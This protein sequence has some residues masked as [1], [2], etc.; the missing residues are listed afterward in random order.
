M[1]VIVLGAGQEVGRSSI[2]IKIGN[3]TI[4]LDCGIHISYTDDRRYPLFKDYMEDMK[5]IDMVFITHFHLDHCGAIPYLVNELKYDGP[6][7]MTKPTKEIIPIL[8]EDYEKIINFFSEKKVDLKE[9]KNEIIASLKN[10]KIINF[11]EKVFIEGVEITTYKAGHVLGAAMFHISYDNQ[12]ILYTG[13]FNTTP[14]IHLDGARV[15]NLNV[16]VLITES[17]CTDKKRSVKTGLNR[18][19]IDT[20]CKTMKKGGNVLLPVFSVGRAQELFMLIQFFED[21]IKE[22]GDI[23]C[24][25]GMFEKANAIYR[26]NIDF[27]SENIRNKVKN[28]M[29]SFD[30]VEFIEKHKNEKDFDQ[31]I[32]IF[33]QKMTSIF[34]QNEK[35]EILSEELIK[36][37]NISEKYKRPQLVF[38]TPSMLNSGISLELFKRWCNNENNLV[39][40]PGYCSKNTVGEKLLKGETVINLH[41]TEYN[42]KM[43]VKKISLSSHADSASLCKLIRQVKPKNIVLVHGEKQKMRKTYNL[44]KDNFKI[45]AET[46]FNSQK[47]SF[48]KNSRNFEI[49]DCVYNF[50]NDEIIEA[51]IEDGEIKKV[52]KYNI[53]Q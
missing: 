9:R 14:E 39:L 24:T 12:T 51:F 42:V 19:F 1:E 30:L 17:T 41:G 18:E 52:K 46:P 44:I 43:G 36:I 23:Y 35:F 31:K 13:D 10:V 15:P 8:L 20:A 29:E 6:I 11:N 21:E 49:K 40:I 26:Q 50:E 28:N 47:L 48:E 3:K 7:Y 22:F 34:V 27:M 5:K 45:S 53:D 16:D 33:E 37:F 4:L 38:A 32:K 25:K 2:L